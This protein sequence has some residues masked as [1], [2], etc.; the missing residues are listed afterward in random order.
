MMKNRSAGKY[1]GSQLIIT[2]YASLFKFHGGY[3]AANALWYC[4][5]GRR[6]YTCHTL[7]QPFFLG[8]FGSSLLFLLLD[9][10]NC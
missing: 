8:E 5:E 4:T 7:L 1:S 6:A 2:D 3:L 9:V 10:L